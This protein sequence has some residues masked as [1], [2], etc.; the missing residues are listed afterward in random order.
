MKNIE[1]PSLCK[2]FLSDLW[3]H[4]LVQQMNRVTVWEMAKKGLA[5]FK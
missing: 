2:T 1:Q 3:W 4:S 5:L